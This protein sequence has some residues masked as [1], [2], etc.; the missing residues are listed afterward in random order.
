MAVE[1][2]PTV[3]APPGMDLK[4]YQ[5][6]LLERFANPAVMDTLERVAQDGSTKYANQLVPIACENLREDRSVK[7]LSLAVA[8]WAKHLGGK[9]ENGVD[10]L[11]TDGRKEEL[12]ALMAEPDGI[13]KLV[14]D[15]EIFGELKG[16]SG[17][18]FRQ[19]I[20]DAYESLVREG[21]RKVYMDILNK[22]IIAYDDTRNK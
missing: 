18:L 10:I 14:A 4:D 20:I 9:D 6:V 21:V 1:I 13:R 12:L 2:A 8:S 19:D 11:V 7:L 17:D 22:V 16:E 5:R 15:K 3:Q